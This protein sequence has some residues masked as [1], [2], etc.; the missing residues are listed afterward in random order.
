M[1]KSE[2]VKKVSKATGLSLKKAG[3]A[4]DSMLDA[5]KSSLRKDKAVTLVSFGSFSIVKR[6]ARAG[7]NPRTGEAIRIAASK[8]PKFKAGKA[9]KDML[10]K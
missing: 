6:K 5:I 2:L 3:D 8:L 9:F 7:R 4:L 1:T 10:K